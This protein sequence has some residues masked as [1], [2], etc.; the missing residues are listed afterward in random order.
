MTDFIQNNWPIYLSRLSPEDRR[1]A[2]RDL[3]RGVHRVVDGAGVPVDLSPPSD[4]CGT[5]LPPPTFTKDQHGR[6]VAKAA[7]AQ[8]EQSPDNAPYLSDADQRSFDNLKKLYEG[9]G[10]EPEKLNKVMCDL[11]MEYI[12]RTIR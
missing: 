5:A 11:A 3:T 1:D 2:V 9:L 10:L 7:P 4:H 8:A 12:Q 6:V